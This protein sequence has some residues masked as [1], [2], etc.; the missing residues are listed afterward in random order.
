MLG[1]A[2]EQFAGILL[3][4]NTPDHNIK[5]T[6]LLVIYVVLLISVLCLP[7]Q[8]IPLLL[9]FLRVTVVYASP[10]RRKSNK[11]SED[12]TTYRRQSSHDH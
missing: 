10:C 5:I 3:I 4:Q 7:M 8:L 11:K 1:A 2:V 9:Q 12:S 6:K